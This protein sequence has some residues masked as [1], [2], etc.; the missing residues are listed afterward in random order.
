M[1]TKAKLP[2][3]VT[4]CGR[5]LALDP[6]GYY[7]QED[8]PRLYVNRSGGS[9]WIGM[10]SHTTRYD[11]NLC[12]RTGAYASPRGAAEALNRAIHKFGVEKF[13]EEP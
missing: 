12:I 5:K 8:C 7:A 9:R 13:F 2:D 11:E 3:S 4:V 10:A 1:T 6:V